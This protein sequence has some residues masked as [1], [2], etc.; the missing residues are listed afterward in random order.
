MSEEKRLPENENTPS[1]LGAVGGSC[2]FKHKWS[3]WEQFE[4]EMVSVNSGFFVKI[5]QKKYCLRCN[6]IKIED[7]R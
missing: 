6:K 2:F 7:V 5:F 1:C 3:K 4:R